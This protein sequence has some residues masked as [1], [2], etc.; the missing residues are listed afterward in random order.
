MLSCCL[1]TVDPSRITAAPPDSREERLRK[2]RREQTELDREWKLKY[3]AD[4]KAYLQANDRVYRRWIVTPRDDR[5]KYQMDR[6]GRDLPRIPYRL[7][8]R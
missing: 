3:E 8:H 5:T 1:L 7:L 6:L 4:W 2:Q